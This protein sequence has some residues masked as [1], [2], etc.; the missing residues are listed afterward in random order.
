MKKENRKVI[1]FLDNATSHSKIALYNVKLIF[2]PPNTTSCCKPFDKEIIQEFE[3]F[4]SSN[5]EG[6]CVLQKH[7]KY[8]AITNVLTGYV[9]FKNF[10]RAKTSDS[11]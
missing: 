1:L 4:Y 2:L 7:K 3:M 9:N 6:G 8:I 11:R 10:V 5:V